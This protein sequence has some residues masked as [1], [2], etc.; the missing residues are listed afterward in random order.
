MLGLPTE[1]D[2][3]VLGIADLAARVMHTWRESASNKN[4]GV[5]ITVSTSWFVP[6][7]HTAFQWEP[8][9]SKEEYERR[10]ALL[11]EA[12]KTKT[13]TYNWHDSDTS[14]LEAVLARGDR[15]MCKVLETAWRKGS[16]LDAWEEYFSL[17]RWLE[18]FEECGLD[19]HFYAN[20]TRS[21]DEK[22]PWDMISSGVTTAYLRRERERKPERPEKPAIPYSLEAAQD[23]PG[24]IFLQGLIQHMGVEGQVLAYVEEEGIR[25]C[26]DTPTMGVL[27]GH[28]G[29]TLDAMQYLTSLAVNRNRKEE[30]YTRVTLD[31]EG[32]RE[33]R[34]ETLARLARKIAGQVKAS[35]RPRELEPMNPYERRVLHASLQNNPYVVT[36]SEGE[37]P[38]RRVVISPKPRE[39]RKEQRPSK[40]KQQRL[41]EEVETVEII[42]P[43][44]DA[45]D[46]TQEQE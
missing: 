44:G 15:R 30:G 24:A 27:I 4:R 35:G 40:E 18:A 10:V 19:P 22:M 46:P 9:I 20:R 28:R 13:V 39:A 8:Q 45:S 29:E 5:R 36:H 42:R 14:F 32:Y 26:V 12:I 25:L 33:K 1:T 16:K 31:T 11:R 21:L 43:A 7:P 34:E 38:N 17:D 6:K 2:E 41:V 23:N 37:E 3:D